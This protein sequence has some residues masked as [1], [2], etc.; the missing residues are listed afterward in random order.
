MRKMIKVLRVIQWIIFGVGT[1][2]LCLFL[3]EI[4]AYDSRI[5]S[6]MTFALVMVNMIIGHL[7]RK[8]IE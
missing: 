2:L 1:I 3:T 7:N 6:L 4:L 5:M 8:N